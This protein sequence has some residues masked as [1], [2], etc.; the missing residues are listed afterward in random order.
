MLL[1]KFGF[2]PFGLKEKEETIMLYSS[3][4]FSKVTGYISFGGSSTEELSQA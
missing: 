4:I 1:K 2:E 3:Q